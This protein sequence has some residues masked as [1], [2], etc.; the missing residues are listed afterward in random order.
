MHSDIFSR[1]ESSTTRISVAKGLKLYCESRANDSQQICR[2]IFHVVFV[3]SKL[4]NRLSLGFILIMIT[5]SVFYCKVMF[6]RSLYHFVI[7]YV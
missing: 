6:C 7:L 3:I 2:N 4:L 1:F 5:S